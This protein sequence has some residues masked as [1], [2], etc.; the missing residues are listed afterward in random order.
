MSDKKVLIIPCS[1][2]GKSLG[3]VGR[4]VTYEVIENLSPDKTDTICL[5]LLTM[6]DD[7]AKHKVSSNYCI[8][9]DGCPKECA[10]K[11]IESLGKKPERSY[12]II[13]FFKDN[14]GAKPSGIVDIGEG[15]RKLSKSIAKTLAKD[16]DD[17][18]ES[19][20]RTG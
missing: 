3:S 17:I 12:K 11:N 1:G 18:L 13:D 4:D 5:A 20:A 7:E 8:A 16:V 9:L 2:I 10:K 6:G 19:E 14:P 15:G